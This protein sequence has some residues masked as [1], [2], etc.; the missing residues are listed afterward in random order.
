[1]P[2]QTVINKDINA[3]LPTGDG[4]MQWAKFQ[5]EIQMLLFDHPVNLARE[6]KQLPAVNSIWCYGL[7]FIENTKNE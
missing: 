1:M 6:A 5:N 4:A 2:L 7:G 3:F